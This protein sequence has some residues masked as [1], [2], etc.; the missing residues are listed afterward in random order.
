MW[1]QSLF[2]QYHSLF[3]FPEDISAHKALHK[4]DFWKLGDP[5]KEIV[6]VN[7]IDKI[8]QVSI[9]SCIHY[10][11]LCNTTITNVV[12]ENNT[13]FL[14]HS[15]CGSWVLTQLFWVLG[16]GCNQDVDQAGI[17][18]GEEATSKLTG[19]LVAFNSSWAS[20]PKV[21]STLLTTQ[22]HSCFFAVLGFSRENRMNSVCVCV[23]VCV[24]V[25]RD[26]GR[27]RERLRM[28]ER[29]LKEL[30]HEIMEVASPKC[31]G[32]ASSQHTQGR[33]TVAV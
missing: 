10:L 33:A 12:A 18:S 25:E 29:D 4:V 14:H 22:G 7:Y 27:E 11:F 19:L 5:S 13:H 28:R 6:R 31:A 23:C 16:K 30:A 15:F 24:C 2:L 21:S 32:W 1:L 20:R 8:P 26:G 17:S 9:T 3:I